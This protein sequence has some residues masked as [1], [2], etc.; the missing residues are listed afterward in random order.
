MEISIR[1][2]DKEQRHMDTGIHRIEQL[3][4][5][6]GQLEEKAADLKNARLRTDFCK[7]GFDQEV[8]KERIRL[9]KIQMFSDLDVATDYV[10]E[11]SEIVGGRRYAEI[12]RVFREIRRDLDE[13]IMENDGSIKKIKTELFRLENEMG[14]AGRFSKGVVDQRSC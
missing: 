7:T 6:M 9:K 4:F 11:M 14:T 2:E 5:E 8:A 3:R 1:E 13:D 12:Q 10:R